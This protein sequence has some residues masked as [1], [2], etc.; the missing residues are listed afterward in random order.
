MH[1]HEVVGHV[2]RFVSM[3][4]KRFVVTNTIVKIMNMLHTNCIVWLHI[5]TISTYVESKSSKVLLVYK[6]GVSA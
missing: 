4:T 5:R 6:T 1:V 2:P 3:L